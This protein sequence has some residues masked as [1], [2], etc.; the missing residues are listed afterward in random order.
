MNN[1][2][3]AALNVTAMLTGIKAK[4]TVASYVGN[5]KRY[6]AF[7]NQHGEGTDSDTLIAWRQDMVNNSANSAATINLR[8]NA[9]RS[10]F[11]ELSSRKLVAR[12]VAWS[13]NDVK[14]L[15]A[16]ALMNR[17]NPHAR[18]RIEPE[19]MRGL[20]N[21]PDVNLTDP[22]AARDRA[23]LMLLATSGVRVS[24]AVAVKVKDIQR[25]NG[26]YLIANVIGKNQ[27][28]ARVAPLSQEAYMAIQDWLFLR[29]TDSDYV[30]TS[31]SWSS[32]GALL[33]QHEPITRIAAYFCVKRIGAKY[34]M[35]HIKPH[36][37]RRFV[38]TQLA[39][40]DIRMAQK[41]LGH[42]HLETTAQHYVMDD[43]KLGTT[44]GLF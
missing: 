31:L 24:E 27:A 12:E 8:L 20:V 28:E 33:F 38:G 19:E 44:E 2:Q 21:T 1:D 30:F 17:R 9:V 25:L 39:K 5:W 22:L 36:D 14:P 16:N 40:T 6:I 13:M 29:P 10:I 18:V 37:F 43:V 23:L 41:V 35:P 42:K 4:N 34:G 3:L 15:K 11:R 7:A 32:E 26:H